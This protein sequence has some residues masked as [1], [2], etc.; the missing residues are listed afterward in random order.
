VI[1]KSQQELGADALDAVAAVAADAVRRPPD[2]HQSLDI[3]V[4]RRSLGA[5]RS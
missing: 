3:E 5:A 4:P 2:A 1:G